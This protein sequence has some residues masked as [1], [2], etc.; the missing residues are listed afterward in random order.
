MVAQYTLTIAKCSNACTQ[1][2]GEL[3]IYALYGMCYVN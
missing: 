1:H 2:L 3:P